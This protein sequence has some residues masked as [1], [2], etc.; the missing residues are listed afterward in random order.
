ME[1]IQQRATSGAPSIL[2]KRGVLDFGSIPTPFTKTVSLAFNPTSE[3]QEAAVLAPGDRVEVSPA[4]AL[5]AGIG[6]VGS[7]VAVAGPSG[8]IE[9]TMQSFNATLTPG[10]IT[11]DIYVTKGGADL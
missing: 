5:L 2:K 7:R 11:F 3:G 6:V 9:I 4:Q 8:A 1:V 10:S